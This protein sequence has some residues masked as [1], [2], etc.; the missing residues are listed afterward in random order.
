MDGTKVGGLW[1]ILALCAAA[2]SSVAGAQD[3]V[4]DKRFRLSPA[5]L[6]FE[7]GGLAE[8]LTIENLT[9]VDAIVKVQA[10]AWLQD[11]SREVLLGEEARQK[12]Q[13]TPASMI[14]KATSRAHIRVVLRDRRRASYRLVVMSQ[15][16]RGWT[17]TVSSGFFVGQRGKNT[18][19]R[20]SAE[21][22]DKGL[23]LRMT[24][25]GERYART[26]M[27]DGTRT[28]GRDFR[29]YILA[30]QTQQVLLEG[31]HDQRFNI[32]L[33]D[34]TVIPVWLK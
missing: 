15:D 26:L 29:R 10:V 32:R 22:T 25:L 19:L 3:E 28:R 34:Q 7:A 5:A 16:G 23:V 27:I 2:F 20:V 6:E 4:S 11:E 31:V 8:T 14:L 1:R 33:S 12:V 9:D 13:I 30:G 24:N 18:D 17:P 21:K